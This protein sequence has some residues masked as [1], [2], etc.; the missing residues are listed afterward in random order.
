[1]MSYEF[2]CIMN[3]ALNL[4]VIFLCKKFQHHSFIK[5][6]SGIDY[7]LQE[8]YNTIWLLQAFLYNCRDNTNGYR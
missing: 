6:C 1:M 4:I 2:I 8:A 3:P 5:L 7:L